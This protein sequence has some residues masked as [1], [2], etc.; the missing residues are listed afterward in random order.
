MKYKTFTRDDF[1][2]VNDEAI[3]GKL[4]THERQRLLVDRNEHLT[5][6]V[7]MA[8]VDGDLY[9]LI[10]VS[11]M[12][13]WHWQLWDKRMTIQFGGSGNY[14]YKDKAFQSAYMDYLK[15]QE[16]RSQHI[17]VEDENVVL[18]HTCRKCSY[19]VEVAKELLNKSIACTNCGH[20]S[21]DC[22]VDEY[23]A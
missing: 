23:D 2:P 22:S 1:K 21:A 10:R 16:E 14:M 3:L 8:E 11:D 17:A 7:W 19:S 15:R 13:S 4:M 9:F 5:L 12:K 18:I 20:E 6:E